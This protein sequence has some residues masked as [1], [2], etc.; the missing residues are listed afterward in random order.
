MELNWNNF[1]GSLDEYI[2]NTPDLTTY[3]YLSENFNSKTLYIPLFFWFCN[4]SGGNC[5]IS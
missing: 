2:G 4:N 1:N 5:C 3:K